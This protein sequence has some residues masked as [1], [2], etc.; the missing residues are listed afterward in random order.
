MG[1]ARN[2]VEHL[3]KMGMKVATAESCTGGMVAA[4]IISVP[5]SSVVVDSSY[6]TYSN[7]AKMDILGVP[8]EDLRREGAVSEVVA[9]KMAQGVRRA[10]G[11]DVGVSA[12]GIAGPDGGTIDK[13][14]GLV[15]IAISTEE[16]VVC[17][18]LLLKG[19]RNRIRRKTTKEILKLILEETK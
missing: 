8:D 1:L 7:Q 4:T 16:R 13:P 9:R 12:T 11:A 5:G 6:V 17:K 18:K 14:V 3:A 10:A 2:V 15:Y 19:T